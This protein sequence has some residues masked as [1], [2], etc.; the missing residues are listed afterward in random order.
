M[1]RICRYAREKHSCSYYGYYNDTMGIAQRPVQLYSVGSLGE[2]SGRIAQQ[3]DSDQRPAPDTPSVVRRRH[4]QQAGFNQSTTVLS[5]LLIQQ[6]VPMPV[7][8][9][10]IILASYI[11]IHAEVPITTRFFLW[12]KILR[13][14]DP[15]Q[16][17]IFLSRRRRAST[18]VQKFSDIVRR[19]LIEKRSD[20]LFSRRY[21]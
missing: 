13:P 21:L 20:P 11:I 9:N 17:P 4:L 3:S 15:M 8:R 14:A 18:S 10:C 16:L 1:L 19:H 2:Q 7:S 5:T 6:Q 12:K